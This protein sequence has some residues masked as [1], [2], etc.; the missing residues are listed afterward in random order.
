MPSVLLRHSTPPSGNISSYGKIVS[1]NKKK[2]K[3]SH[4]LSSVNDGWNGS[5]CFL[6]QRDVLGEE[7]TYLSNFV[8]SSATWKRYW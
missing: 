4:S 7:M 1:C 6:Y 2:N 8:S 3:G 5:L